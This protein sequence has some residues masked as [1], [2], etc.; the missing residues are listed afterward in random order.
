[1]AMSRSVIIHAGTFE[2]GAALMSAS[3]AVY[4]GA[5]IGGQGGYLSRHAEDTAII[6]AALNGEHA[7]LAI[8]VVCENARTA[9][10]FTYPCGICRQLIL[11]LVGP[12]SDIRVLC[13]N[14]LGGFAVESARTLLPGAEGIPSARPKNRTA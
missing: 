14:I 11:N 13:G 10:Q 1:M 7:F 6:R 3:G 2:V 4:E 9:E 5:Y 12:E 8:A